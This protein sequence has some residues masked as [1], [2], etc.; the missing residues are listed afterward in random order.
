MPCLG[1]PVPQRE[2]R[3][4]VQLACSVGTLRAGLVGSE[5]PSP[6]EKEG[7]WLQSSPD[8]QTHRLKDRKTWGTIFLYSVI[9][10][11]MIQVNLWQI[12]VLEV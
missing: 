12:R 11:H 1:E 2:H 3:S 8:P 5:Y 9:H 6:Q 10:S 4:D 7:S